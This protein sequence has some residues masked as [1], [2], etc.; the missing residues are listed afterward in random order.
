MGR[1]NNTA[2][3]E[4]SFTV[5]YK[6]KHPLT[7]WSNNG[8]NWYLPKRVENFCLQENLNMDVDSSF[9][10]SCQILEATKISFYRWMDKV[11][12]IQTIDYSVLKRND[13]SSHEKTWRRILE[14]TL[15]S[16]RSQS[17]RL[18]NVSFQVLNILR[19]AKLWTKQKL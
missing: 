6:T 12:N 15:L 16:K 3:L 14:C 17:E 2:T 11:W 10:Q 9:I 5:P 18:H 19:K 1:Q 8:S 7:I 13:L 4:D